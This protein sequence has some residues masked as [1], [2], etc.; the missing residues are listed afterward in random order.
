LSPAILAALLLAGVAGASGAPS[1]A[2]TA[3]PFVVYSLQ[4]GRL[5]PVA[6]R[7]PAEPVGSIQ[8]LWIARAWAAS[9]PDLSA[10]VP[11]FSC[12]PG[13]GCWNRKGH[14]KL[15]LRRATSLSCNTYF[16]GLAAAVPRAAAEETFREAGFE[17][18]GALTPERMVGLETAG[19]PVTIRP[20]RLLD[21]FRS[22]LTDPWR[23]R[24]DVRAELIGGIRDA[25]ED[26]T[27]SLVPLPGMA[28][29]TGTVASLD[30]DPLATSGWAVA[31]DPTGET[32]RLAL[33]RNGTGA[34]AAARLAAVWQ[35]ESR[36]KPPESSRGGSAR[37]PKA[38]AESA[39][40]GNPRSL[41]E[42]VRVRL[43]SAL[44]PLRITA[45]N[46]GAFP[47]QI[48]TKGSPSEWV[49]PGASRELR[50]GVRLSA[51]IWELSVEPY[52][53]VR[54]VRGSLEGRDG[55]H[56]VLTAT[57]RDW[58]EGVVRSEARELP[59]DRIAEFV[60]VVLRFL[61]RGNRHGPEDVCDLS[62]CALFSGFGPSV[63][64]PRPDVAVPDAAPTPPSR[65]FQPASLLADDVWALAL[66]ASAR[67]GPS[68]WSASCGGLPLTERD[69]WGSG[70][71]E[72]FPCPR[73]VRHAAVPPWSRIVPAETFAS[74]FGRKVLS[75]D[76]VER[77]GVRKTAL[78][79]AD[80]RQEL[81]WDDLHRRLA[82]VA[83]WDALPSPPDS[84]SAVGA[85]WQAVGRGSGHRVGYC[86][87]E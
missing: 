83:G 69:V 18:R 61:L 55:R 63:T 5:D 86:L 19:R 36:S 40:E 8:K 9:H 4:G 79:F 38:A 15:G 77:G 7:A 24:E 32:V 76:A 56:P 47:L 21:S 62:H 39:A 25:A 68:L 80:G 48:E 35:E 50:Q 22:L 10:G 3:E 59:P 14:G 44:A 70:A 87:G 27:G 17:L 72:P 60:P 53:L 33:L 6:A 23:A 81:L 1:P 46:A 29:K 45:T 78:T 75:V 73:A 58:V 85:G 74:V 67:P 16:L 49:G 31:A 64:W 42:T 2:G 28:V 57:L 54:I 43:F 84:W 71:S 82:R 65:P 51:G 11:R 66:E 26:G 20:E 37:A 13:S 41:P 30:G 34:L 12:G 52:R